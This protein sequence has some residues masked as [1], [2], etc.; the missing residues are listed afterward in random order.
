M[1]C[2]LILMETDTTTTSDEIICDEC[3][4]EYTDGCCECEAY[5]DDDDQYEDDDDP[6]EDD[7]DDFATWEA[8]RR[9]ERTIDRM[10]GYDC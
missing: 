3:E 7:D 1:R 8:E 2:I 6:Y 9:F 5:E 10:R 4:A